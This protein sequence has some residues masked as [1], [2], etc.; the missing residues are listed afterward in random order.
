[1]KNNDMTF[2]WKHTNLILLTE[3]PAGKFPILAGF[4]LA[5]V[6]KEATAIVMMQCCCF[7]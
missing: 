1:L 6:I 3:M 7:F 5:Q 4:E 2:L